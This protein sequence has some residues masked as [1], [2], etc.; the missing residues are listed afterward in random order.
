MIAGCG[1]G[2]A[3]IGSDGFAYCARGRPTRRART[4]THSG[5]LL[6]DRPMAVVETAAVAAF[7]LRVRRA[8]RIG[9]G[10]GS[11]VRADYLNLI[12]RK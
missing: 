9:L 6:R 7:D 3:A 11:V 4:R 5:K 12:E 8:L 1:G 10:R 2:S